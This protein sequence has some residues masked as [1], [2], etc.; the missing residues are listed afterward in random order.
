MAYRFDDFLVYGE[1]KSFKVYQ[2][3]DSVGRIKYIGCTSKSLEERLARHIGA[4][5]KYSNY[6]K[7]KGYYKFFNAVNSKKTIAKIELIQEF[8]NPFEASELEVFLI[9]SI[10]SSGFLILNK[11]F[12]PYA[13]VG[14]IYKYKWIMNRGGIELLKKFRDRELKRHE[15][16]K[17][18]MIENFN[19][20]DRHLTLEVSKK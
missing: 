19:K 18:Q 8:D 2:V 14:S 6:Q 17:Q 15:I 5:G 7:N 9:S 1:G 20:L 13:Q 10:I 4:G 16:F 3:I 12:A 11:S